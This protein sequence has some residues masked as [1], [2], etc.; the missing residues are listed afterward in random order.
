[1]ACF[2]V[3][4]LFSLS[5]S[6]LISSDA[7][8]NNLW[9][10]H[11]ADLSVDEDGS[12]VTLSNGSFYAASAPI[13]P[14]ISDPL[15]VRVAFSVQHTQQLS[16]GGG[17]VK[18]MP[19]FD[20]TEFNGD[21]P[22]S[23]MF[24]PDVCGGD[25]KIQAILSYNGTNV[26][27]TTIVP[28]AVDT[29]VHVYSLLL[30]VANRKYQISVDGD[31]R[32][33]GSIEDAWNLLASRLIPDPSVS[34]PDDWVDEAEIPDP[35]DVKPTDWEEMPTIADPSSSKPEDWSD[36]D[37]GEW[38]AP[39]VANPR[40]KGA[41]VQKRIPNPEYQGVWKHPTIPNPDFEDDP[42]L[43]MYTFG[44]IGID[45]WQVEAGTKFTNITVEVVHPESNPKDEL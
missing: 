22:Y 29:R 4:A 33:A 40:Y 31:V 35:E 14:V 7:F 44:A 38:E 17:Y 10:N 23:I 1:M 36:D 28:I 26:P 6:D 43:C 11:S 45:I 27:L 3:F 32:S 24:G 37:D 42:R 13:V 9:H 25:K 41:W 16:C 2:Q 5:Q 15:S 21:T 12:L 18:L 34:K 20:P 19:K 39:Q 8:V 30:N